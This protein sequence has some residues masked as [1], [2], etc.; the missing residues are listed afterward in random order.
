[1]CDFTSL[2]FEIQLLFL[3]F[4]FSV[5]CFIDAC[6]VRVFLVAEISLSLFFFNIYI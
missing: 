5:Y 1:M 2:S 3:S 6:V 4:L